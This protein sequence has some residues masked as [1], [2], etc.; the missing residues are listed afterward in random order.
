MIEE[1]EE[2]IGDLK[3]KLVRGGIL[4]HTSSNYNFSAKTIIC[5]SFQS[6]MEN[7]T[8]MWDCRHILYK[9]TCKFLFGSATETP[10]ELKVAFI[11]YFE[12]AT[13]TSNAIMAELMSAGGVEDLDD[14]IEKICEVYGA[15]CGAFNAYADL[16]FEQIFGDDPQHSTIAST[17]PQ[18]TNVQK[19]L[20][21]ILDTYVPSYL[22]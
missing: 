16:S 20:F 10:Q 4:F 12:N 17:I 3:T 22:E 2:E 11:N 8:L 9:F 7:M 15:S 14:A 19:Q 18:I 1:K 5:L 13:P 6:N 21:D